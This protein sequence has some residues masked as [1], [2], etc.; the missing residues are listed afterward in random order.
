MVHDYKY[1]KWIKDSRKLEIVSA[2]GNAII[3]KLKLQQSIISENYNCLISVPPNVNSKISLP[4]EV[5]AYLSSK[6]SWLNDCSDSIRKIKELPPIKNITDDAEKSEL[7]R[8][9]YQV[10]SLSIPKN[11][12]GFLIVD[13]IFSSGATLREI[14]RT[15]KRV[16]PEIPIYVI[17]LTHLKKVWG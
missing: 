15:L 10:D 6:F 14:S 12:K 11:V 2:C 4:R 13:D 17:T 7:L 1:Q 16:F 3:E 5:A 9:A 8:G